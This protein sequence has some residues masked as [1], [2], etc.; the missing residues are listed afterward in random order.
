MPQN[1]L[2]ALIVPATIPQ[3]DAVRQLLI[4]GAQV[5]CYAPAEEA[6]SALPPEFNALCR[7]YAPAPLG[8]DLD[9]FRQLVR[10]MTSHR[11]EYYGGGLS[12]LSTQASAVD[13]ESV[14]RLISRLSPQAAAHA[15]REALVQAR[16]L[17]TL[18]EVRDQEER[19]IA[20]TL[21]LIDGQGQAMLHGLSAE[22]DDAEELRLLTG[23]GSRQAS[24]TLDKR[25]WAWSHLFL[26]DPMLA[27]HWLITTTPEVMAII[28]DLTTTHLDEPPTRLI[29]LPL[30]GP[31]LMD[32]TPALYLQQ[33]SAWQQQAAPSLALVADLLHSAAHSGLSGETKALQEQWLAGQQGVP[34]WPDSNGTSLDLFLL[35]CSLATLFAKM[36][37]R[38][39]PA[40]ERQPL[41]YGIVAVVTP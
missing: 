37:K 41:A 8:A 38:A 21:A 24:D 36:A 18:A 2:N 14:W 13:E 32:L 40:L 23:Q 4:Y 10:D 33:R 22:D 35:P 39:V 5:F 1:L 34:P 3:E 28:N 6:P 12:R 30:P 27:D 17:L 16:L 29:S 11:A 15:G 26:T 7:H 9:T 19:E 31:S 25:L 20:E